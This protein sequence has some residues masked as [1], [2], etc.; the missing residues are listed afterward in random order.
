LHRYTEEK[1]RAEEK[2]NSRQMMRAT[3]D[4]Y[5]VKLAEIAARLG[6][7]SSRIQLPHSSKAPGFQPLSV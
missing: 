7:T 4:A 2:V 3:D 5:R 1:A 6:C